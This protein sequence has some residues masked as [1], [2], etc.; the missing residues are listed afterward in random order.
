[1]AQHRIRARLKSFVAALAL[2][3]GAAGLAAAPPATGDATGQPVGPAALGFP[4]IPVAPKGAPNVLLILTDDVGYGVSSAFGGPVP[5]P[6]LEKLAAS[7]LKYNQFHSTAMCSPTRAALLTGRNHHA[8]ATGT[9]TDFATGD[10]GY[11]SL[12]PKSAA[13]IAEVLRQNGYNTAFFGKEHNV[14]KGFGSAGPFDYWPTRRGFDYFLGFIGSETDQWRPTLF[15]NM[16]PVIEDAPTKILDERLADEAIRWVHQQKAAAPDKPFFLY[17]ATGT[18]HTPHQAPA[19]WIAKFKGHYAEGWEKLREQTLARQ[20]RMGIVPRGTKLPAWPSDLPHWSSL[21]ADERAVQERMM[22]AFA[23]MMAFQDEQIGRIFAE[24]ERMG[25][26]DNT[27]VIFVEGDNGPDGAAAPGGALAE[28]GELVNR[29][30][31]T[32]EHKR[33]IDTIGGPDA[34]S[35]YGTGW[36][37]AMS[38]PFPFYKSVASHLGGTQNGAVISWPSHIKTPGI[39]TQYHHVIDVFPTILAAVG[40]QA[41]DEVDGVRQQPV[42]GVDMSYSFADPKAADR[43]TEQYYE[44]LGNRAIYSKGWLANTTPLRRPWE[45]SVGPRSNE[46]LAPTYKWELYN[47]AKDFSQSTNLAARYPDKLKEMQTLF[48]KAAE[49][50]H[51]NPVNDRTD[52]GRSGSAARAY[53]HPRN[54]YV[55]WGK[56]LTVQGE[57]GPPLAGRAFRVTAEI[58]G[59][60]GTIA[61]LGSSMGGWSFAV[62]KG[63]PTVNH[64]LSPLPEDQFKLAAAQTLQPGKPATV[65]FDFDYDGGGYGKGGTVR[66]SVNGKD[67]G[68]GRIAKSMIAAETNTETFDVGFDSGAKVAYIP[69]AP[70]LF[71]G[72]IVKL[73]FDMGPAG[74]K[75]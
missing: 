73:T 8:V 62:E 66:I 47:I 72:D 75:R 30:L 63:R 53:V 2:C 3:Q 12:L 58:T 57:S 41:P 31:N 49:K 70:V 56:G 71:A 17:Y 54:N 46:N 55:Y 27:L 50:Y 22:E 74:K 37:Q 5:M 21:S 25:Q 69:G 18:G 13:S 65:V 38:T 51:V 15:R 32:E 29:R 7:G 11:N 39:R 34:H 35:N 44:M 52:F 28:S 9:L 16:D 20:I 48:D 42:D 1:M 33:L 10:P 45:M 59:G 24:L 19:E 23:G 14:P 61:A 6:N 40:I 43:H 64:A 4:E 68:E 36:A 26:R 60:D 67:A